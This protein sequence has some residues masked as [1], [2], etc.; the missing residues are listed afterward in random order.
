VPYT[1]LCNPTATTYG[2][3]RVEESGQHPAVGVA[4]DRQRNK[5]WGQQGSNEAGA[6]KGLIHVNIGKQR[7]CVLL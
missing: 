7:L 3:S 4:A 6:E 5:L 2:W 1:A